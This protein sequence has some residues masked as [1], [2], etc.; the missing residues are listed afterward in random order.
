MWDESG[1]AW[2]GLG[3]RDGMSLDKTARDVPS[4]NIM[5]YWGD[6]VGSKGISIT[7]SARLQPNGRVVLR[8]LVPGG[9]GSLMVGASSRWNDT[10]RPPSYLIEGYT[11][12][13]RW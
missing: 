9:Y 3:M 12:E 10:K 4:S 5:R 7:V 6:E 13:G 8:T 2:T 11:K 1:E